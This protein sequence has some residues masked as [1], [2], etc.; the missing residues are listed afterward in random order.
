MVKNVVPLDSL[1]VIGLASISEIKA[2]KRP[3]LWAQHYQRLG[4]T[5]SQFLRC[6]LE[7]G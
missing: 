3:M 2:A 7:E 6:A 1:G 5:E 4:F